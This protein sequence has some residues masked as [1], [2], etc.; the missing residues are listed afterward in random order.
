MAFPEK[1]R[2]GPAGEQAPPAEV[3][4]L[5]PAI[6]LLCRATAVPPYR[7]IVVRPSVLLTESAPR[8]QNL[9]REGEFHPGVSRR[10][11]CESPPR[12]RRSRS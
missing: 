12:Y 6:A 5:L 2:P 11:S 7:P 10:E 8:R 3:V 1:S 9:T 4:R